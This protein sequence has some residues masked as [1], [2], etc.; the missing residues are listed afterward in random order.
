MIS[1][2]MSTIVKKKK[3]KRVLWQGNKG[4]TRSTTR[5][6]MM[7]RPVIIELVDILWRDDVFLPIP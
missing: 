6:R 2:G 5:C 1:P 4:A 3:I 7:I